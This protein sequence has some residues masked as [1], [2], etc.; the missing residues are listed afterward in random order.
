MG[1]RALVVVSLVALSCSNGWGD[2]SERAKP[3]CSASRFAEDPTCVS[4]VAEALK[5]CAAEY[6]Y[7][8][9]SAVQ[10]TD[11]YVRQVMVA[12]AEKRAQKLIEEAEKKEAAEKAAEE[13]VLKGFEFPKPTIK[14][15]HRGKGGQLGEFSAGEDFDA[16]TMI[17]DVTL[18][19]GEEQ[20]LPE[21]IQSVMN[22]N[23]GRQVGRCIAEEHRRNPGMHEVELE[24]IVHGN[25]RVTAVRVN[26]Q[27][28]TP[29]ASCMFE[30]MRHVDFPKY[31][32]PKTIAGFSFKID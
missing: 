26:G 29:I 18:E 24:F 13:E 32:G 12:F 3:I 31:N 21:Q 5:P 14:K 1:E 30:K 9:D 22:S 7:G 15:R 17:G 10:C 8:T 28:G 11:R 2:L 25:G 27:K 19:G 6:K 4:A 20:L 23:R 16:P